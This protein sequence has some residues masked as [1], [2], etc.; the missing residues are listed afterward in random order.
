[1]HFFY[2]TMEIYIFGWAFVTAVSQSVAGTYISKFKENK[3]E[4]NF[5]TDRFV[6]NFFATEWT[7]VPL[8]ILL[9]KHQFGE[10]KN[11]KFNY[12]GII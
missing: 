9:Q 2:E 10:F 8:Q 3:I 12:D 1:M 7:F 4:W 11:L 6:V 5:A